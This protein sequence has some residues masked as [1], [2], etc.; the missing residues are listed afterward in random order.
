[1]ARDSNQMSD[2]VSGTHRVI[3]EGSV[4]RG[5][6]RWFWLFL[7]AVLVMMQWSSLKELYYQATGSGEPVQTI[8]WEHDFS[9]AVELAQEAD[10]P[11]LTVFGASWCPPCRA[12]KRDVWPDPEVS[13]AVESR[14]V[15]MYVDVDDRSQADLVSRYGVRSI[16]TILVLDSNGKVVQE[17][18]SMS[19][20]ETLDF[21][22]S[23]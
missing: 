2:N 21:L 20:S 9:H 19:R 11:I 18:K 17:R 7:I 5:G 16:P 23:F 12:M 6:T 14:F 10:K 4:S 22:T 15:P 8:P 13:S 3:T 1:M